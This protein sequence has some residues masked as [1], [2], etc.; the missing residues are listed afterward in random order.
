ML[1]YI[2]Y[3]SISKCSFGWY[4]IWKRIIMQHD[5]AQSGV[6]ILSWW[7]VAHKYEKNMIFFYLSLQSHRR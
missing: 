5:G 3:I 1:I 7:A 2:M 6:Y 4:I